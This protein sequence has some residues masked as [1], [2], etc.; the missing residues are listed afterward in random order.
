MDKKEKLEKIKESIQNTM[1]SN[2]GIEVIDVGDDFVCGKMPI[3]TRTVQSFG[4]L[5]GGA[6]VTLAESLG[7]IAGSLKIDA[8]NETVM[9]IEINANHLQAVKEGWVY[10]KAL[11]VKIGK[12]IQVWEIQITDEANNRVCISRLTL[13]IVKKS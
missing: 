10:G 2:I 8:R 1:I 4:I 11:P 9:G 3:D 5:H 7:S 6:S 13:A 12:R